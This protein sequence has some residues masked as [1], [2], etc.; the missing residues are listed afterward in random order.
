MQK[1]LAC[2]LGIV[3]CLL[4]GVACSSGKEKGVASST[5]KG[6]GGTASSDTDGGDAPGAAVDAGPG[7]GLG[8]DGRITGECQG[9]KLTGLKY[10]PGG[11]KL[12]NKCAP[13]DMTLNNP[14]AVRCIDAI[15]A[16]KTRFPGDEYCILPPPADQGIQV[17]LHPQG[18]DYWNQM[19]AGDMSGYDSAAGDWVMPPGSETSQ[20]FLGGADNPDAQSYYR[21]YFRMRTGSHHNII[22]LH[23]KGADE[24][25]KPSG[26]GEALPGIFDPSAGQLIGILGGQQRPDD[27]QPASLAKPVEDKGLYLKWPASPAIMFNMHHINVTTGDILR[28]GWVNIWWESDATQVESWFMGL[29]NDQLSMAVPPG[30]T[31]DYHYSWTVGGTSPTRLVRLFGHRHF[32]TENFSAWI[33]HQG[34]P[35]PQVVYQSFDWSE[36]PTYRYDSAAKNPTPDATL[37]KDGAAS[38]IVNLNPGDKL[39]FNCHIEYTDERASTQSA[40]PTP[41]SNGTLHFAN[42]TFKAEMC[43]GFGNVTAGALGLPTRDMTP[44]PDFA[45]K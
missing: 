45:T 5:T 1:N 32:W 17:G 44:V 43:I 21:T 38:G 10:S 8:P 2:F 18:A 28:E 15:P 22:T 33:E 30:Q 37:Q 19:W 31:V 13:F 39:H 41:E 34:D 26:N 6:T 27:G 12:P 40:A 16:F 29:G 20:N 3:P 23:M 24:G 11:N 9:M 7:A 14:Y 36:M 42:E 25:W 4:F 35:N